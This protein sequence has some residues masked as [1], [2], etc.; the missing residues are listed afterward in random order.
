M[1]EPQRSSAEPLLAGGVLELQNDWC[2]RDHESALFL[3]G[4]GGWAG[5]CRRSERSSSL[6]YVRVQLGRAAK[7]RGKEQTTKGERMLGSWEEDDENSAEGV[8]AERVTKRAHHAKCGHAH[9]LHTHRRGGEKHGQT[10]LVKMLQAPIPNEC[11]CE[12]CS[13]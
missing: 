12:H 2:A 13:A 8:I 10:Y 5:G 3:W 11:P 4:M 1:F 7:R 6:L 9:S